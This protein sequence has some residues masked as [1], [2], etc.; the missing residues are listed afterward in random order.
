[1]T[2]P[3]YEKIRDEHLQTD[4]Q[5]L[6]RVRSLLPEGA[7]RRQIWLMFLDEDHRQMPIIMPSYVPRT[8]DIHRKEAFARAIGTIFEEVDADSLIVVYERR[9]SDTI[10]SADRRWLR[11]LR[12][13]CE[14][15]AIRMRGPIL[16]HDRGMRWVAADDL[17]GP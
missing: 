3:P 14:I 12:D 10:S 9:G 1:M 2:V 16:C 17:T 7:L 5:V 4:E 11:H 13:A 8:P 6:D 15:S